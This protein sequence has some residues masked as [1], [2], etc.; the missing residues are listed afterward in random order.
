MSDNEPNDDSKWWVIIVLGCLTIFMGAICICYHDSNAAGIE[1]AKAGL[2]QE[3]VP[4][5]PDRWFWAK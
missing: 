3:F 5:Q 4:N 1:M 2:H